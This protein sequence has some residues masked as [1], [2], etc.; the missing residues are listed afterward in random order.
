[1]DILRAIKYAKG[2]RKTHVQF[3]ANLNPKLL[4]GYLRLL[5]RSGLVEERV[6]SNGDPFYWITERGLAVLRLGEKF[7]R[8]L[9]E[10]LKP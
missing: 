5:L 8:V 9:S 2:A 4:D 10:V 1:M 3:R 7:Y 6:D